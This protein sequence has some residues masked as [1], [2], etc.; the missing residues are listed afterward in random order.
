MVSAWVRHITT[1]RSRSA[2]ISATATACPSLATR[3]VT[4][5]RAGQRERDL[6]A[7]RAAGEIFGALG[8]VHVAAVLDGAAA[9]PRVLGG[10]LR[11]DRQQGRVAQGLAAV[12][13]ERHRRWPAV[14]GVQDLAD[15]VQVAAQ[16]VVVV[17]L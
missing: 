9:Q 16:S 14:G 1:A 3:G 6:E 11:G 4:S 10:E 2:S 15:D 5:W 8:A 7:V 12:D 17:G 13:Q